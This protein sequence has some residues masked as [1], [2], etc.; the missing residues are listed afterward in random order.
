[1][2]R[3]EAFNEKHWLLVTVLG[4]VAFVLLITFVGAY[5]LNVPHFEQCVY[6]G[7][8]LNGTVYENFTLGNGQH[9]IAVNC[10]P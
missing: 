9:T 7:H 4:L 8:L 2:N 6:Q 1:M 3:I 5:F 10:K